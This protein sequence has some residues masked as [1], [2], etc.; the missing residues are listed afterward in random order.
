MAAGLFPFAPGLD[1]PETAAAM[2]TNALFAVALAALV[3]SG[4][5]Q[6]ESSGSSSAA[7]PASGPREIEITANDMMKYS[8]T[9]IEAKPGEDIKVVLTNIG[10]QP[11]HGHGSTT[12]CS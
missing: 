2:K 9:N 5:G 1:P 7:A 8:L 12:G 3:T 10:T 4:C 11:V 6:K